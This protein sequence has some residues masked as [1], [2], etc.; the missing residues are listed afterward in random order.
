MKKKYLSLI[1]VIFLAVINYS[2]AQANKT[3]EL[4]QAMRDEIKR[5]MDELR[6]E[7]LEKPYFVE[8]TLKQNNP[9]VIKAMLGSIVDIETNY[10][11]LIDVGLRVGSYKL[12]NS[13]YF[14]IGLSFFGSGDDEETFTNRRAP[15]ELDYNTLRRELWLATDAAYKQSSEI[16]SKKLATLRNRIRKD[17][18]HDFLMI[19]P[20]RHSFKKDI[21]SF[22]NNYFENLCKDLS[23]VF[24]EYPSINS[25]RVLIEYLPKITYYVNSEGMEFTRTDLYIGLETAVAAQSE[26]GMPLAEFFT[27]FAKNPN[28][29]PSK[30]S[31]LK[32]M[33]S[34]AKKLVEL[35]NAKFIEEPY[36]G[37]ILFEGQ[38]AAEAFAQIFAPNLVAQRQPMTEGGMRDSDRNMAFQTKIGGRVLPE[39]LSVSDK[40]SIEKFDKTVAIGNYDID[41]DGVLPQNVDLVQDGYLKNLLSSRIPI[42]RVKKSTG[43]KRGGAPM[44]SVM[45]LQAA[46]NKH[47][48][49]SEMKKRML[50]LVKDRE[51]EYGIIA[52]KVMNQNIAYTVVQRI[53]GGIYPIARDNRLTLVE[54]YKI[55][56]NGKEELIRGAEASGLTVQSFKDIIMVDNNYYTYNFLA[57]SVVSAFLTGGDQFVG[58]T[59]IVP[60]IL[61][62]DGEI[63]PLEA[64]FP[65]PPL[66]ANPLNIYK[67]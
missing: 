9:Y 6:L 22:D 15:I 10:L 67:K 29:L 25:S 57:P 45:Q 37:P 11:S 50:K 33:H 43:H 62:E 1:I 34:I 13:N 8:Y 21:P 41:D 2:F 54:A 47:N 4:M 48:S 20:Q 61:F 52:R 53:S 39:F 58:S 12:D 32:A 38:A 17:T 66:L 42:R 14:D 24:L 30:D 26:D 27:A 31:L 65:K 5:T 56:P 7:S 16:F 40:P 18:T 36:S 64:D 28:D 23:A 35:K 46:K 55:Y 60:N 59:V 49:Y 51:L 63:R 44:F 19:D 3:D